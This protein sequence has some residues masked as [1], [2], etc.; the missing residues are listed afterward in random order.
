MRCELCLGSGSGHESMEGRGSCGPSAKLGEH[1][2]LWPRA[3]RERLQEKKARRL[4]PGLQLR[5]FCLET[6]MP[7]SKNRPRAGGGKSLAPGA[8]CR[9]NPA[10]G[11]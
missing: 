2:Q 4:A 1:G 6:E 3:E 8:A 5:L 9:V 10:P 11:P 7:E